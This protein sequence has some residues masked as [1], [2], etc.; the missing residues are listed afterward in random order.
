MPNGP[1]QVPNTHPVLLE[2][3]ESI[4]FVPDRG[5]LLEFQS[6]AAKIDGD[7]LGAGLFDLYEVHRPP[8]AGTTWSKC[9]RIIRVSTEQ[10][11]CST[12]RVRRFPLTQLDI[13]VTYSQ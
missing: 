9:D 3:L 12:D 11:G 8:G 2:R 10:L 1:L 7:D 6:S 5:I 4:V 13:D